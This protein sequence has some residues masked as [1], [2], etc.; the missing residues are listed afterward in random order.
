M[1]TLVR[2]IMNR[3][4]LGLRPE[5]SLE[6]VRESILAMGVTGAPV[7]DEDRRPL[8]FVSLRDLVARHGVNAAELMTSP[9]QTIAHDTTVAASAHQMAEGRLHSLVVIDGHGRAVGIV[10]AG[11]LL[12]ELVDLPPLHPAAFPHLDPET[13]VQW[14]DDHRLDLREVSAAPD[15][16]GVL[17]LLE[18]GYGRPDRLVWAE[19]S[20][21]V[22]AR[23]VD[24]LTYPQREQPLL[25]LWLSR[26]HMRFRCARVTEQAHREQV[27][28]QIL[29][30]ARPQTNH[31][32]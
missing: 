1:A 10:S 2:E 25:S 3:E 22:Q 26:G 4:L 29:Q 30:H 6:Q 7:L 15:G 31:V 23:L 27:W 14:T 9:A 21:D 17:A 28:M 19:S 18:G 32:S 24:L 11:D 12:R 16:P 20:S 13:G 8:G 5:D